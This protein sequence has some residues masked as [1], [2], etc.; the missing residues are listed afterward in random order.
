MADINT[1]FQTRQEERYVISLF[2][3]LL[4]GS[5]TRFFKTVLLAVPPLTLKNRGCVL[6][7]SFKLNRK[8]VV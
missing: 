6:N 1:S 8:N 7:Q 2:L 3:L 5:F 4:G